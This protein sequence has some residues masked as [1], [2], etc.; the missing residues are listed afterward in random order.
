MK[1]LR[2]IK[3]HFCRHIDDPNN[4]TY[5]VPFEG[6]EFQ[7]PRCKA[8]VAYFENLNDYALL[9]ELQHAIVAEEGKKLQRL[10]RNYKKFD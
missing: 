9:S 2:T 10:E 3:Q 7:C 1:I 5:V 4:R 6:Y 8:Y